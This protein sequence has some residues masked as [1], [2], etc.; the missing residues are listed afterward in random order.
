M[1]L[2]MTEAIEVLNIL[3]GQ[4]V[5]QDAP[6]S[7]HD[8]PSWAFTNGYCAVYATALVE[9]HPEWTVVS[10]GQGEC[11][12]PDPEDCDQYGSGIC[13]CM[14]DH[15]YA[16]SPEGWLYD[17]YGEH[18][19]EAVDWGI[20]VDVPDRTLACVL[21]CWHLGCGEVAGFIAAARELVSAHQ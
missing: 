17:V 14:V 2:G 3:A 6:S 12:C 1:A 8:V 16:K 13:M 9:Q 4:G 21:E 18:D 5:S 7:A 11:V 19:P 15:F 10:V 20:L